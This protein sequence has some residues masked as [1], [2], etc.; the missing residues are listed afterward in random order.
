MKP[1]F[2]TPEDLAQYFNFRPLTS[3]DGIRLEKSWKMY[4]TNYRGDGCMGACAEMLS[5]TPH[6][7]KTHISNT[8]RIDTYINY[9]TASGHVV[10]VACERKTSG[11]RIETIE[12]E[13]SKAERMEGRYV[14]YSLDVCNSGTNYLRRCVPAVVIPRRLFVEKLYALNAVKPINKNHALD[15]YGIQATSKK[16]FL[17]LSDWPIV[18]DREAVYSDDDFEGLE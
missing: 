11:G 17:W 15:G 4:I 3:E 7:K 8:G 5:A 1:I 14:I 9:R 12:S 16:L 6:S 10:P 2:N 13:F 18:F